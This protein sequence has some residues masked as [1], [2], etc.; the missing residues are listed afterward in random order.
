MMH[1]KQLSTKVATNMI[2]TLYL[3]QLAKRYVTEQSKV[4]LIR[5][6]LSHYQVMLV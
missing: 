1:I 4:M 5:N 3:L 2:Q 6:S